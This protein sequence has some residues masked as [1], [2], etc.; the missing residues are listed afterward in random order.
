MESAGKTSE[1]VFKEISSLGPIASGGGN[2]S[3]SYFKLQE[4][5]KKH[6][7]FFQGQ[8]LL[9]LDLPPP[10]NPKTP[11]TNANAVLLNHLKDAFEDVDMPIGLKAGA[12]RRNQLNG[13]LF[14]LLHKKFFVYESPE[15]CTM[16]SQFVQ[17]RVGNQIQTVRAPG[18]AGKRVYNNF[19]SNDIDAKVLK[20]LCFTPEKTDADDSTVDE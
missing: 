15:V 13:T 4:F 1:E 17:M 7:E 14:P 16:P 19:G 6:P 9:N 3:V 5:S 2:A 18:G 10:S 8:K 20:N 12:K 11:R